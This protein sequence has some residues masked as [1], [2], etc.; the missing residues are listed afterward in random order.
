[1]IPKIS[2]SIGHNKIKREY[3]IS[4]DVPKNYSDQWKV[5]V[6]INKKS[7]TT[8][9]WCNTILI[10]TDEWFEQ[11]NDTG[12]SR[13]HNYLIK[14]AWLQAKL[15]KDFTAYST[16]WLA[17]TH[18]INNFN[19]KPR[20]YLID[21]IKHLTLIATGKGIG[22]KPVTD[23]LSLPKELIR[24]AYVD[25]YNLK[26]YMPTLMQPAKLV[27]NF[28]PIYYSLSFPILLESSS[29][30][31]NPPS[32]IE[33]QRD[34]KRLLDILLKITT[35]R[36]DHIIINPLENINFD[37][38]HTSDDPYGQIKSSRLVPLEDQ[39]FLEQ[40]FVNNCNKMFCLNS[41]FFIGCIK[42]SWRPG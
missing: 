27:S 10:F 25:S 13:F 16:L 40:E 29:Y 31:K 36:Q 30:F 2:D 32:I 35:Q 23:D 12:I 37:L 24:K 18:E 39:R 3:G 34:I 14:Q 20:G 17:F 6:D 5:F 9:P 21:T 26:G 28:T 4:T 19:L 42:I 11:Q 41:T 15:L 38:F 33:D 1:M 8:T 7:A 22:F